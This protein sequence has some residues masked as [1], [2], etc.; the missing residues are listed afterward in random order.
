MVRTRTVLNAFGMQDGTVYNLW[1]PDKLCTVFERKK[2]RRNW[3]T[4]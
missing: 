1:A 3:R 4:A 2:S